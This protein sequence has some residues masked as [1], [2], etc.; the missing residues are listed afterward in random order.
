MSVGLSFSPFVVGAVVSLATAWV[1]VSRLERVGE[2]PSPRP[3]A[4]PPP[5]QAERFE[6]VWE[7]GC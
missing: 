5:R 7:R 3:A 6:A 4:P 2:P 1:L